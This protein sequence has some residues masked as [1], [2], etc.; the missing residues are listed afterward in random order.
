MR[1][2][3]DQ[4]AVLLVVE[5]EQAHRAVRHAGGRQV[6]ELVLRLVGRGPFAVDGEEVLRVRLE[7]AL[8]RVDCRAP[9]SRSR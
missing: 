4:R 5:A 2:D 8:H 6:G 1:G 9:S 7:E 3:A